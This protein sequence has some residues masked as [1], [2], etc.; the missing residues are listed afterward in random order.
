MTDRSCSGVAREHYDSP[1]Y[2]GHVTNTK[3]PK[4]EPHVPEDFYFPSYVNI[5][6]LHFLYPMSSSVLKDLLSTLF[7]YADRPSSTP[8]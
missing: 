5:S 7:S 8:D 3:H 2:V 6:L 4:T 1:S